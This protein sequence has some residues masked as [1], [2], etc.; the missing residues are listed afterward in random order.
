MVHYDIV[1]I[2]HAATGNIVPFKKAD[3]TETGGAAA[4]TAMAAARCMKRVA[5]VTRLT[6][7][8]EHILESF[9]AVGIDTYVQTAE[10]T[11]R[12]HIFH[13]SENVDEREM[14]LTNC[15]GFFRL[16][17][18]PS[19]EPCL[20]H[21]SGLSNQEFTI[22]FIH[23]LKKRGFLL[24]LDMQSFV[25]QVDGKTKAI[26]LR[27]VPEKRE[28][29]SM[30]DIV[31]LDVA[32]AKTITGSDDLHEAATIIE[33]WGCPEILITR[34]DGVLALRN[35]KGYFVK[36]TN[37]SIAGRTGRGDTTIG[38]YLAR[39]MDHPIEDAL[40]FA[41]AMASIKMETPGPYMGTMEDVLAR[42]KT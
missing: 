26:H 27:D 38:A 5:L 10:E 3:Y 35:R 28:I 29:L 12:I 19:F 21:L 6:K 1:F 23:G 20:I 25:F 8:D 15:A 4:F 18:M 39:R 13:R 17:E 40:Q 36:F 14:F 24:S 37:R 42:M 22:E 30:V 2:G 16:E 31:K 7:G 32:E 11:T 9:K 41:A 33:R 34:S